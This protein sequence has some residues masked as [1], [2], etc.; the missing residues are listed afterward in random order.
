MV[1]VQPIDENRFRVTVEGRT[2]LSQFPAVAINCHRPTPIRRCSGGG[3]PALFL[4]Q[5]PPLQS[6]PRVP[7]RGQRRVS[8]LSPT[9]KTRK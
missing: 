1:T 2:T 9:K 3:S 6:N 4:R 8:L 5:N 7:Y